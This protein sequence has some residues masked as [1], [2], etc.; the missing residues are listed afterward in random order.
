MAA[1]PQRRSPTIDAIYQ[2]YEQREAEQGNE[3]T[4]LG[5]SILGD[6]C[7][8][9]LWYAFRWAHEREQFEGRM[10]RLFETGH[11]EE[12][13]VIENLKS[14]GIDIHEHDRTTGEQWAVQ[15]A[16]GH[17]RGHLDGVIFSGV[18]EAPKVCHVFECKT[19]SVKSFK[20]LIAKGVKLAKPVHYAQMQGYMH[21]KGIDRALY[22]AVEKDTDTIQVERIHYDPMFAGQLMAKGERIVTSNKPPMKLHDDPNSRAAFACGWCPSYGV[23]HG[24]AW[25]RTN[26]RTCLH[27]TPSMDG[28]GGWHCGRHGHFLT[29]EDQKSG[30][31][32]HLFIP[33]LVP[34]K[35]IDADPDAETVTYLLPSGQEWTDGTGKAV[36]G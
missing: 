5:L 32:N 14:V 16:G 20:D 21:L 29:T 13:R 25:P 11:R 9:K 28:D 2:V 10:L 35:Q 8:R 36:T 31:P 7:E 27:S 19:H 4:Y 34:G 18:I 24:G 6:E 26:C 17:V 3:R 15:A 1:I 12:E 22:V 23:C 30:C 33:D